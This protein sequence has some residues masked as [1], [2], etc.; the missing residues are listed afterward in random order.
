ML[1]SQIV[2]GAEV[3]VEL[4]ELITV[5]ERTFGNVQN[6]FRIFVDPEHQRLPGVL[7]RT[8]D[9]QPSK[10][11]NVTPLIMYNCIFSL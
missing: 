9:L 7:D 1:G 8:A 5:R 6:V 2:V 3:Y 10:H 4:L 11:A